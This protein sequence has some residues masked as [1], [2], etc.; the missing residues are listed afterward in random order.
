M[1]LQTA[2]TKT[3]HAANLEDHAKIQRVMIP[4][5]FKGSLVDFDSDNSLAAFQLTDKMKKWMKDPATKMNKNE[6]SICDRIG[7]PKK[8]VITSMKIKYVNNTF[9]KAFDCTISSVKNETMGN[10]ELCSFHIFAGMSGQHEIDVST[11]NCDIG[12]QMLAMAHPLQRVKF[13]ITKSNDPR[14]IYYGVR[15]RDPPDANGIMKPSPAACLLGE[16]MK[17]GMFKGLDLSPI[18][19]DQSAEHIIIPIKIC[20]ELLAK[21]KEGC[22]LIAKTFVDLNSW[23]VKISPNTGKKFSD[24][25]QSIDGSIAKT[26]KAQKM[27]N[28][29]KGEVGTVDLLIEIEYGMLQ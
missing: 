20:N 16:L 19:E 7:D 9:K 15:I 18:E 4:V 3:G 1:S 8:T 21:A 22:D 12:T 24:F 6:V 23:S 10:S 2:T 13:D 26:A 11:S 27:E 5:T 25:D 29:A 14:D 17:A 28:N